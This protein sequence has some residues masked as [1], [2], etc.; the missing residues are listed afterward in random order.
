MSSHPH[1]PVAQHEQHHQP[2]CGVSTNLEDYFLTRRKFLSRVG[3]GLGALSLANIIDPA[4]L[5]AAQAKSRLASGPLSPRPS[6]FPG[7]A[8]AV[9]HIFA[10]GAPSH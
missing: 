5:V 9:I 3:M 7:K 10:S 8:K 4:H 1:Y 6:H 2:C